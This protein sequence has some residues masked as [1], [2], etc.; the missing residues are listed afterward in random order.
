MTYYNLRNRPTLAKNDVIYLQNYTKS[1]PFC[2]ILEVTDDEIK[3]Q[4]ISFKNDEI[5]LHNVTTL[6][7]SD[8]YTIEMNGFDRTKEIDLLKI[9]KIML[10]KKC[11]VTEE[12]HAN[13]MYVTFESFINRCGKAISYHVRQ[14][15]QGIKED[16]KAPTWISKT[17]YQMLK[18]Y[19]PQITSNEW[20]KGRN[21]YEFLKLSIEDTYKT[22]CNIFPKISLVSSKCNMFVYEIFDFKYL[23][24]TFKIQSNSLITTKRVRIMGYEGTDSI[25]LKISEKRDKCEVLFGV[26]AS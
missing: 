22:F 24:K 2:V 5:I 3:L 7:T 6:V 25:K 23:D 18:K 15:S 16:C 11:S 19:T 8:T 10:K 12:K 17:E 20:V 1:S 4:P 26:Y 21:G 14:N 9:Q 13:F